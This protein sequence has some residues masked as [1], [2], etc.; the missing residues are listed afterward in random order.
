M[1]IQATKVLSDFISDLSYYDLPS[2]TI[3]KA[4]ESMLDYLGALIAA[5]KNS[6]LLSE[7]IIELIKNNGGTEE[8]TIIG[9]ST[10][11][12][13][14]NAALANGVL[15]HVV[16]LDD[17]HR[18]ARGHPG[19][20]VLSAVLPIAEYLRSN[21]KEL[22]TAIV[23]GY[24]IFVRIASAVNPSH[25][26]RGYHTTGTCGT[27]AAA[28]AAAKIFNLNKEQ[29]IN[30][31]GFAGIQAAGLLE[32]TVSGQTAK[33]LHSGK[34]AYAGVLSAILAKAGGE[35]PKAI[36]EGV[37]GFAK[38]MSDEC[39]YD[40]MLK[41]MNKTYC[42]DDCYIKL[43]PS[44]RHTHSPVDA[45]FDMVNEYEFD[46]MDISEIIIRT[47]PTAISFAGEIFKPKSAAEAKFSI[48]YCV[49]TALVKGKLGLR[50]LEMDCLND[51]IILSLIDKVKIESD[52]S[53]E[54][55]NPK[56]K[57]A[58]LI[59]TLK[60]GRKMLKRVNLPKGEIENPVNREELI[61]KFTSCTEHHV[62]DKN[63]KQI[64]DS[65]FNLDNMRD[66]KEMIALLTKSN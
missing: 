13:L 55:S 27:L 41:D 39:N 66:I 50:Q 31:L 21:G 42:I 63:R 20:V 15:S 22:I 9:Q 61:R 26:N 45:V 62:N 34:A 14:I 16:E 8:A 52:E 25:L 40:V 65:V 19:V 59:V 32:V 58:E 54:S 3:E 11:V 47:F 53:L 38:T 56:T 49:C 51:P 24:D 18:I 28:A 29:T 35:G 17:G 60:D 12:P 7:N 10:K 30:A 36:I 1:N 57:G 37:K 33:A 6:S 5:Y 64:I 2:Y 23:A 4:K 48:P 43:Y 46:Y 44:C